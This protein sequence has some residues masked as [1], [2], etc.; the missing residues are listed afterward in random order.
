MTITDPGKVELSE[1]R[2][3]GL[4]DLTDVAVRQQ[5][6]DEARRDAQR[7][8]ARTRRGRRAAA[9]SGR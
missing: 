5:I 1:P 2:R 7:S 3:D 8:V 6:L 4:R 9:Q